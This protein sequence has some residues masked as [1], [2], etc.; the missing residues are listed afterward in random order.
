MSFGSFYGDATTEYVWTRLHIRWLKG[1]REQFFSAD[2]KLTTSRAE[3]YML[4]S[5][6][7]PFS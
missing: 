7:I 2:R 4:A 5:F 3:V 1:T 6:T